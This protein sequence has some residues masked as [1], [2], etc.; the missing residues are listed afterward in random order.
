MACFFDEM[1]IA[2]VNRKIVFPPAKTHEDARQ[3]LLEQ[4]QGGKR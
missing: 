3:N 4:R 1:S 2:E